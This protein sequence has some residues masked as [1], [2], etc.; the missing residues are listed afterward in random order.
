MLVSLAYG[1]K[2]AYPEFQVADMLTDKALPAYHEVDESCSGAELPPKAVL[3]P[4]WAANK[5]VKEFFSRNALAQEPAHR[6]LL[7]IA[8]DQDAAL[9]PSQTSELIAHMCKQGD[10]VKVNKVSDPSDL[11]V[12]DS[13][14]DQ[15]SWME[16]RFAGRAVATDCH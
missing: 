11:V 12:G 2:T 10:R 4:N 14:R 16:A 1:I 13:V 6:P 8:D 9:P 7:I 5:F 3:K 15:M